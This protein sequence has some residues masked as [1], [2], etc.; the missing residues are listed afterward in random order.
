MPLPSA[1]VPAALIP[2]KLPCTMFPAELM[3]IPSSLPEM[4]LRAP[5][6]A[7]PI[8]LLKERDSILTPTTLEIASVPAALVPIK[9]PCTWLFPASLPVIQMP[10]IWPEIRLP[11]PDAVP[12]DGWL[13]AEGGVG[14]DAGEPGVSQPDE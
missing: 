12:P 14:G 6:C 1:A 8:T 13:S 11:A 5:A 4:M 9:L 10:V 2:M 7:P 3:L